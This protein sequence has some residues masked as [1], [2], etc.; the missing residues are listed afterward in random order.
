MNVRKKLFRLD[1]RHALVITA[2]CII[3]GCNYLSIPAAD[4]IL[5]R[6]YKQKGIPDTPVYNSAVIKGRTV[7]ADQDKSATLIAAYRLRDNG[8]AEFTGYVSI[9]ANGSFMLYLPEGRYKLYALTDYNTNGIFENNEI[10]GVCG[11]VSNPREITLREGDLLTNMDIH[12]SKFNRYTLTLPEALPFNENQR[13]VKQ[14]THN[15]QILKIYSEYFSPENAQTGYWHPSSFMQTFGAHIYLTEEYTPRKIPILFVHGTE[16]SPHSWI[17]LCMRLDR[18]RYQPF[19]YYYP[20]GVRLSLSAALLHE[21]L[22]ELHEK[23]GFQKMVVVAHSVGGLVSRAFISRYVSDSQNTFIKVFITF[24]T[25]W[26][27]FEMADASQRLPHKSIPAWVDL[28]TQSHFIQKVMNEKLPPHIR[29]YIFYGSND[30]LSG[31]KAVDE[32]AL[33]CAVKSMGFDCTHDTI[34]SNRKVFTEFDA[35]LEKELR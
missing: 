16:G 4:D 32:R 22:R 1:M 26:S 19:F 17:Y 35:I 28:G 10:S 12:V 25:P 8:A 29:H 18:S 31:S 13:I 5:S 9:N 30:K 3:L 24:A 7:S 21:E 11:T 33:G 27:G 34:L 23:Y 14:V 20:S 6:P 15:G 2:S